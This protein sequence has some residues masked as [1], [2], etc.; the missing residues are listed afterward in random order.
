[1]YSTGFC[2]AM[3]W[4]PSAARTSPMWG[5]ITRRSSSAGSSTFC[6]DSGMR[7]SSL[8]KST[9]PSRM[10]R[11][12]G[13]GK[14]DSSEYP[15]FEHQR[16]VEP[17][18]ELALGVAVVAVDA[19]R[20]LAQVAAH[21]ERHGRLA[22]AHRPLEQEVPARGPA[23][24]ATGRAP[25]RGRRCRAS[26]GC[27]APGSRTI[28]L[29]VLLASSSPSPV[30]PARRSVLRAA[31]RLP[32]AAAAARLAAASERFSMRRAASAA[33]LRTE[34]SGSAAAAR[35]SGPRARGSPILARA[36]QVSWRTRP[37]GSRSRPTSAL[38]A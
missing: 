30:R 17:A 34:T 9:E 32:A 12:S 38:T 23:R 1:M 24:P 31:R 37:S 33:V 5:T 14:N 7:L 26:P 18:G 22:D 28:L 3:T 6:T 15:R 11:T 29:V 21:G 19:H 35:R 13:P 27:C 20:L 10:A 25:G 36:R 4:K 8:M 16:R 2:V